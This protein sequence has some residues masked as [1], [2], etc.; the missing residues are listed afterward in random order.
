MAEGP[1]IWGRGRS[2]NVGVVSEHSKAQNSSKTQAGSVLHPSAE[3]GRLYWDQAPP[4]TD[5]PCREGEARLH[6]DRGLVPGCFRTQL[7]RI[8]VLRVI[9]LHF[10]KYP[11]KHSPVWSQL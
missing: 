2:L 5:C 11:Q 6:K 10:N 7:N 3:P 1:C 9:L 8:L 4:A